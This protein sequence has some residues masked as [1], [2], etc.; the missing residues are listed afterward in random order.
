VVALA[1]GTLAI[2]RR[3]TNG[4]WDLKSYHLLTLGE[5]SSILDW[6]GGVTKT[7]DLQVRLSNRFVV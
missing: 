5:L 7:F 6:T 2:F 1:N 4:E 3:Q